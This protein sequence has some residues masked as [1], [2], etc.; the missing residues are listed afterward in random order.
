MSYDTFHE[1]QFRVMILWAHKKEVFH[2]WEN[3]MLVVG[4][5]YNSDLGLDLFGKAGPNLY[6]KSLSIYS[7]PPHP[8]YFKLYCYC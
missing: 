6:D 2:S 4:R 8:P 7:Y 1:E 5:T 3:E